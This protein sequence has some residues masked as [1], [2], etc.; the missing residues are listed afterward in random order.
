MVSSS[1]LLGAIHVL[2]GLTSP[3]AAR[4]AA[5]Q[6]PDRLEVVDMLRAADG[7]QALAMQ[8]ALRHEPIPDGTPEHD[9]HDVRS[10]YVGL[11]DA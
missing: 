5:A 11:P 7:V 10:L 6:L 3:R 8:H 1:D 4:D 2:A 9:P